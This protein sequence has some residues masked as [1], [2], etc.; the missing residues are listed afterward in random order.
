MKI[1]DIVMNSVWYDPRVRK[2]IM[3]YCRRGVD[4]VC[5]GYECPRYDAEKISELPCRTKVVMR[6]KRFLG[7]QKFVI[8]K[9]M[10]EWIKNKAVCEAIVA[11]RP[12]IIHANDLDALIPAYMAAKKVNA[13]IV[14]DSHEICVKNNSLIGKPLYSKYLEFRERFLCK[15]VDQMVCVSNAAADYFAKKYRI[16]KPLVITNCSLKSEQILDRAIQKHDGFEILNHGQ[17]Y[18]GRGFEMLP[19]V[20]PLIN[21]CPEIKLAIRG[22]G[23]L[24]PSIHAA[25]E[26]QKNADQ[27]IFYPPV[28]VKELIPEA[29]KSHV[30]VA[31]T[32]PLCLNFE[33]S[34]SNKLFEYA[35]AGLPV[36]MSNIPEHRYLNDQ[37]RFGIV[38]EDDTPECFAK[39]VKKLYLN[40]EFY[41]KC[42]R[43]A[44]KMSD[45]VNWENSFDTLIR[46]EQSWVE[47][48]EC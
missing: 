17:Y 45:K 20:L 37:Y 12:D 46:I 44:K 32:V 18:S 24:E 39:A 11:E 34:V 28:L 27:F 16:R 31:I 23:K 43:G 21:D 38:L 35:A 4:V 48:K 47:E 19:D 25:V 15:K 10:R 41:R 26:A 7:K 14:Y 42:V 1:C 5:V 29:S 8:R 30:G 6:D 22:F 40:K 9:F 2:Q 36:I 13:R 33:L 3:E